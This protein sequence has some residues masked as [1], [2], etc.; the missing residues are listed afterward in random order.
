MNHHSWCCYFEEMTCRSYTRHAV[1][2]RSPTSSSSS[3][4]NNSN[5]STGTGTGCCAPGCLPA[6]PNMCAHYLDTFVMNRVVVRAIPGPP[7]LTVVLSRPRM[8]TS[9]TH[10]KRDQP[11]NIHHQQHNVC[12][13]FAQCFPG[14]KQPRSTRASHCA[15]GAAVREQSP[16]SGG[17]VQLLE[18]VF[19]SD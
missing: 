13:S 12:T 15:V 3:G 7:L 18:V 4:G 1:L 10:N 8:K 17:S 6:H 5:S 2:W 11:H 14:C 9:P 19:D 16:S